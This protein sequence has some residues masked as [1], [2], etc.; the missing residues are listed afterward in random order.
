MPRES[1]FYRDEQPLIIGRGAQRLLAGH[2]GACAGFFRKNGTRAR[3]PGIEK[4]ITRLKVITGE[5]VII[6]KK[7]NTLSK[8]KMI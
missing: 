1:A 8:K 7:L 4:M 5:G 2:D 6:F 3:A